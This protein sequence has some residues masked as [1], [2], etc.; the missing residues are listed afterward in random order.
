M[1]KIVNSEQG[2]FCNIRPKDSK[3]DFL[4]VITISSMIY[5]FTSI[6][7]STLKSDYT[8][9]LDTI[10]LILTTLIMCQATIISILISLTLVTVQ[11]A[12]GNISSHITDYFYKT[13]GIILITL[14]YIISIV[15]EFLGVVLI[16]GSF[17]NVLYT[18]TQ[19]HMKQVE[20]LGE[21]ALISSFL[22]WVFLGL[23]SF[24][25]I[26]IYLNRC[27]KLLN[28]ESIINNLT[29]DI[30]NT[31]KSDKLNK[32]LRT[33]FDIYSSALKSGNSY[34]L[35][36]SSKEIVNFFTKSTILDK[37]PEL[38]DLYLQLFDSTLVIAFCENQIKIFNDL[39]CQFRNIGTFIILNKKISH[40]YA[41]I[42]EPLY[43]LGL[44]SITSGNNIILNKII[45]SI[46]NI[47]ISILNSPWDKEVNNESNS[48]K[49]LINRIL[50]VFHDLGSSA[51]IQNMGASVQRVILSL[52]KMGDIALENNK[53]EIQINNT[54]KLITLV[55]DLI[56]S[57]ARQK[58]YDP[59]I[60]SALKNLSVKLSNKIGDENIPEIQMFVEYL[61]SIEGKIIDSKD[62]DTLFD[63]CN[64][65]R[66][67]E[68]YVKFE[69]LLNRI[70]ERREKITEILS[71][72]YNIFYP[73]MYE[74]CN[75]AYQLPDDPCL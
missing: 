37:N 51:S 3:F 8:L 38:L 69:Y 20:V 54:E 39:L 26:P 4:L 17:V 70:K 53:S 47:G 42:L 29:F 21:Q 1:V 31:R 52:S 30:K 6:Y 50:I 11:I 27:F 16:N 23:V 44:R 73:V 63:Y 15:W 71:T 13:S 2:L 56:I 24:I 22:P 10:Q 32:K 9:S 5:I 45:Y 55:F 59:V 7:I 57:I 14:V 66:C 25:Y 35:I 67:L 36:N 12:N 18:L 68:R 60:I 43:Q 41:K 74:S 64:V 19:G 48:L 61:C 28:F 72:E 34:I 33:I 65:W 46:L 40:P 49:F 62:P 58:E 75:Q